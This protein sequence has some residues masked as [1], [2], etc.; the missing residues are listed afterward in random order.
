[1]DHH[2][3]ADCPVA[4]ERKGDAAVAPVL[5]REREPSAERR[6]RA[7]DPVAA[8][9]VVALIVHVHGAALAARI[10]TLAARQLSH[11]TIGIHTAGEHMTVVSVGGDNRITGL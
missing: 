4:I 1:M 10:A 5:V 8:E 3:R 11:H 9:K 6:L 2:R 7:H